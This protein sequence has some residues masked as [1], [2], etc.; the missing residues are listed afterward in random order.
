MMVVVG[1]IF[2]KGKLLLIKHKRKNIWLPVGGHVKEGENDLDALKRE[3]KEEVG[4]EVSVFPKPFFI[5]EEE[6]E[7]T[8][9][10]ICIYSAGKIKINKAEISD[11]RWFTNGDILK[12][13]L[14]AEVKKLALQA[15]N[16]SKKIPQR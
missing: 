1:F 9:H 2:D 13:D 12:S 6:N 7:T 15:F 11:Y 4:L 8:P 14:I 16:I 5:L 3:T 10:H